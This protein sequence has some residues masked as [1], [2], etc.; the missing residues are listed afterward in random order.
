MRF[1]TPITALGAVIASTS[2]LL[3]SASLVDD[4]RA[5]TEHLARRGIVTPQQVNGTYGESQ[6]GL[7][8]CF[9][10]SAC[11]CACVSLRWPGSGESAVASCLSQRG[12]DRRSPCLV[13]LARPSRLS[14][15]YSILSRLFRRRRQIETGSSGACEEGTDGERLTAPEG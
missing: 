13:V 7:F 15:V 10:L 14:A 1:S 12:D 3:V 5:E 9:L 2:S 8:F 11:V 6:V 4:V